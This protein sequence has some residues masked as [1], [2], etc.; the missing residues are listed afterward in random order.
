MEKQIR[1]LYTDLTEVRQKALY[2]KTPRAV[3]LTANEF[4]V[5]P[6]DSTTTTPVLRRAL[7]FPVGLS[8]GAAAVAI[9]FNTYG[10]SNNDTLFICID[11][12]TDNSAPV[13]S[14][15]ITATRVDLAKRT[16]ASCAE[17]DI[18]LK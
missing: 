1:M 3:R 2:E 17:T 14:L 18:S 16:G 15:R 5:Y 13:D 7:N 9:T 11:P 12:A 8:T 6:G 10:I 4:T